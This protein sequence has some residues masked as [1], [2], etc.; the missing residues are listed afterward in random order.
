[1]CGGTDSE[2]GLRPEQGHRSGGAVAHL[3]P[4]ERARMGCG[5]RQSVAVP[6]GPPG[7]T[8][9][10]RR[11]RAEGLARSEPG[12]PWRQGDLRVSELLVSAENSLLFPSGIRQSPRGVLSPP[13]T[14]PPGWGAKQ[15]C[16]PGHVR[17]RQRLPGRRDSSC[18]QEDEGTLHTSDSSGTL[19]SF[20]RRSPRPRPAPQGSP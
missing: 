16:P 18:V 1:M 2:G 4:Q 5:N 17:A 19:F 3:G 8:P 20:S 14:G 9:R 6:P 10:E 15:S 12:A 13:H 7:P 11:V